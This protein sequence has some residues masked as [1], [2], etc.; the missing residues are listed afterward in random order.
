MMIHGHTGFLVSPY[1]AESFAEA[2]TFLHAL[3]ESDRERYLI[4]CKD[5][6]ANVAENFQWKHILERLARLFE[7]ALN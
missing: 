3:W 6:Q 7:T 4:M 5:A 1:T 2:A